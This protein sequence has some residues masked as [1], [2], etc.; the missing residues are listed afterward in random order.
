M[1]VCHSYPRPCHTGGL[2]APAHLLCAAYFVSLLLCAVL[3]HGLTVV[4]TCLLRN[5]SNFRLLSMS[6]VG[7]TEASS[8]LVPAGA[9][10]IEPTAGVGYECDTLV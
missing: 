8:S 10:A 2:P 4:S 1:A 3:L 9:L 6:Y 5:P 7:C